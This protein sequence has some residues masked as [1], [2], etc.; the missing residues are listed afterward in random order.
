[1]NDDFSIFWYNDE[2]AQGLFY[3]LLARSEQGAYDDDFLAQ[4]AAYRE[5]APATSALIFSRRSISSITAM[6]K[7]P[8]YAQS[9]PA[10]GA[11]STLRSGS[12]SP[13]P[14]KHSG[15]KAMRP[16]CRAISTDFTARRCH[17]WIWN[18]HR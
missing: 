6:R 1:M 8:P 18:H 9:V 11:R 10:Q 7:M 17:R 13:P 5:A 14:T 12:S 4:L 3:D 15:A 16:P 2:H